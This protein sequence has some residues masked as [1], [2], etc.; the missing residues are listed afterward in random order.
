MIHK[1]IRSILLNIYRSFKIG[2]YDWS[3]LF[4]FLIKIYFLKEIEF[5]DERMFL[6]GEEP[7]LGRQVELA[8]DRMYYYAGVSCVHA[9]KK[10]KEGSSAFCSKHWQNSQLL[11][12]R[13]YSKQPM[14]GKLLAELSC[15]L[16]FGLLNLKHRLDKRNRWI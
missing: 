11:Y 8:G 9:H 15:R 10:S 16:Y 13:H 3:D 1:K 6:Y 2:I 14:Y 4:V 5:F 7:I 12:I